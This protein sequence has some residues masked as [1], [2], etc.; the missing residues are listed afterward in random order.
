MMN[1]ALDEIDSPSLQSPLL[2]QVKVVK[3]TRAASSIG[4]HTA[5]V[6]ANRRRRNLNKTMSGQMAMTYLK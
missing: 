2:A 6:Q 5:A 4:F 1:H 3:S